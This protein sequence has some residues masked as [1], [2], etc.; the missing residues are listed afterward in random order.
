MSILFV[1]HLTVIDASYLCAARGLVGE[2]W[3]VDLELEGSLDTQSMVLDFGLVKKQIKRA[4]DDSVDHTLIIP[5]TAQVSHY[6]GDCYV[7]FTTAHGNIEQQ[8]PPCA[9]T[10]LDAPAV[11]TEAVVQHL[12][13]ILQAVVPNNVFAVR[14]FLRHEVI[15]GAYFHYTHGLKKHQGACSRIAHGHRS[16]LQFW[17]GDERQFVLEQQWAERWQDVYLASKEDIRAREGGRVCVSYTALEGNFTLW[18]PE[19]RVYVLDEDT[20]IECLAQHLADQTGFRV[21][22]YEGV[23]KGAMGLPA[24]SGL[25][26]V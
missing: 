17:Q 11:T 10:L 16:K 19:S 4:I 21:R 1:E 9:V 22:V 15:D 5:N 25:Q 7:Y 3:I 26:S 20:T 6:D 14:I 8:S 2:S 24:A 23:M 12:Q 13:P 18:L